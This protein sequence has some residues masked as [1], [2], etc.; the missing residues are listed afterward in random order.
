M[1]TFTKNSYNQEESSSVISGGIGTLSGPLHGGANII[2]KVVLA[3]FIEE[4]MRLRGVDSKNGLK[5]TVS[6]YSVFEPIVSLGKDT[7][8]LIPVREAKG[9]DWHDEIESNEKFEFILGDFPLAW[10]SHQDCNFGS[11]NLKRNKN[12][13]EMLKSMKFIDE[14]GAALYLVEPL[15]F[16]NDKGK[17]FEDALNSEGY[18]LNAILNAPVGILKPASSIDPVFALIT[19]NKTNSLFLA[20]LLNTSQ[21]LEVAQNFHSEIIGN[22]LSNGMAVEERGFYGFDNLK[23]VQKIEKLEKSNLKK[24]TTRVKKS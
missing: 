14:N 10:H 21:A 6:E 8:S 5:I 9:L 16:S 18:F 2:Q 19:K 23:S 17:R 1:A 22:D 12:W 13:M 15:C 4:L 24:K 7:L 3:S 20:D 11:V